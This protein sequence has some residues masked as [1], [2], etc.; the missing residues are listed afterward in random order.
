MEFF[1]WDPKFQK[2]EGELKWHGRTNPAICAD[3]ECSAHCTVWWLKVGM[4][5]SLSAC[6]FFIRETR[7]FKSSRS[8]WNA[9]V[10]RIPPFGRAFRCRNFSTVWFYLIVVKWALPS[11]A[12]SLFVRPNS[13]AVGELKCNGRTNPPFGGFSMQRD[14]SARFGS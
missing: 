7:I 12:S 14:S 6:K 5:L 8:N 9:T 2:A 13:K 11:G 4:G 3:S 10:E 1:S